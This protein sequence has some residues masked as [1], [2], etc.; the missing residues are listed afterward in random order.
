MQ[1]HY[2]IGFQN[3]NLYDTVPEP[4]PG[5][6]LGIKRGKRETRKEKRKQRKKKRKPRKEKKETDDDEG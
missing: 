4:L 6:A 1:Y 2:L 5:R 3:N